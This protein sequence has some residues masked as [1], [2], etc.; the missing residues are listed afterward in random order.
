MSEGGRRGKETKMCSEQTCLSRFVIEGHQG[1]KQPV[2]V[3]VCTVQCVQ[4]SQCV[5]LCIR[6][7]VTSVCVLLIITLTAHWGI[8]IAYR[9]IKTTSQCMMCVCRSAHSGIRM[10]CGIQSI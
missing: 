5:L 6:Q 9:E 8:N 4:Q 2:R 1:S 3:C 7:C 10:C